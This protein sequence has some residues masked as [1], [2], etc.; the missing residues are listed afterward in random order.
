MNPKLVIGIVILIIVFFFPKDAG[1]MNLAWG[2]IKKECKCIGIKR[3][4]TPDFN[5]VDCGI[6]YQ[7]IGIPYDC[8][9][10]GI[11]DYYRHGT[12][13]WTEVPCK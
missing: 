7:C 6:S 5:C 9:C 4:L 8:K 12:L 1:Y 3:T 11:P 10:Y 13:H 2:A